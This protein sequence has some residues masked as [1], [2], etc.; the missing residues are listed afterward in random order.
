LSRTEEENPF[1]D[2][3]MVYVPYCTGDVFSGT[4]ATGGY[5]DEP[6]QGYTNVGLY[7]ERVVPTFPDVDQVVLSGVSAGGFG[8]AWNSGRTQDAFGDIPV[9]TLDDSGPPMGAMYFSPCLAQR[10]AETWGWVDSI[11]PACT[12]CDVAGGDV[13]EPLLEVITQRPNAQR[14]ALLS[15]SE[16]S[17]IK[18]FYGFGL[19]D[20]A[21]IDSV[22]PPSYPSGM[23]PMGLDEQRQRGEE[24]GLDQVRMW[25]KT[26]TSH[27]F[28][29]NIYGQES[30][31][32]ALV[33]W[34]EQFF[35][36]DPAWENV[37]PPL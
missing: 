21:N 29:G 7:L 9:Y 20:C 1:K 12:D 23:F 6:Q 4:K 26:G 28:L 33:D 37:F 30:E 24:L 11:H 14:F 32:V 19:D 13:V 18:L 22:L 35:T 31:G 8:A 10:M 27:T 5:N 25:V 34:I 16:D 17:V 15:N 2:W 36:D 3:N